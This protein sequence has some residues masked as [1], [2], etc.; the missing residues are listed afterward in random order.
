MVP[1][2]LWR[3]IKVEVAAEAEVVLLL[4]PAAHMEV[5]RETL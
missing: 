4:A 5:E 3:V 1:V 2:R